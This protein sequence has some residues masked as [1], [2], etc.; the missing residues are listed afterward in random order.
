MRPNPRIAAYEWLAGQT[1]GCGSHLGPRDLRA[2]RVEVLEAVARRPARDTGAVTRTDS[3]SRERC[4]P[5]RPG[6]AART[7][8]ATYPS[9]LKLSRRRAREHAIG[10]R[11][12]LRI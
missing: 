8:H 3:L 4:H 6:H 9:L 7:C 2:G 11:S 12:A 5:S 10:G 1:R